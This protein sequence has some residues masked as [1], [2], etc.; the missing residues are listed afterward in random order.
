MRKH[1]ADIT[2]AALFICVLGIAAI[3]FTFNDELQKS[4]KANNELRTDLNNALWE[5]DKMTEV[6]IKFYRENEQLKSDLYT[7]RQINVSLDNQI[8][9][10]ELRN[11]NLRSA[12]QGLIKEK[13]VL[14]KDLSQKNSE[15]KRAAA[16][17]FFQDKLINNL[18]NILIAGDI[19]KSRVTVKPILLIPKDYQVSQTLIDKDKETTLRSLGVVQ[20]WFLDETGVTFNTGGLSIF[21]SKYDTRYYLNI[22]FGNTAGFMDVYKELA[23]SIPRENNTYFLVFPYGWDASL[24]LG[25]SS[26][27]AMISQKHK[28][29]ASDGTLSLGR[30]TLIAAIAHELGHV[31]DLPHSGDG[32]MRS[33]FEVRQIIINGDVGS[34]FRKI[35]PVFP[36]FPESTFS[37]VEKEKIVKFL[38]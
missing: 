27:M 7:A 12:N 37:A 8:K 9:E 20:K 3:A 25:G 32:I 10:L 22:T 2:V 5:R 18:E 15:A 23:A 14:A 26:T 28:N 35:P 17:I 29:Q 36:L 1:I 16:F 21:Q 31:M 24:S 11:S 33:S 38:K 34:F 13:E 4:H 30:Y 6:G 19:P